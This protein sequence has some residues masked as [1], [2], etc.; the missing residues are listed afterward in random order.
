MYQRSRAKFGI[1][2]VN[3]YYRVPSEMEFHEMFAWK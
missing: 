2:K 3:E 1:N